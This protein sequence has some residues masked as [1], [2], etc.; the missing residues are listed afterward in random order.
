MEPVGIGVRHIDAGIVSDSARYLLAKL[1]DDAV[2]TQ[3]PWA[4]SVMVMIRNDL[5]IG[6]SSSGPMR[7]SHLRIRLASA[8]LQLRMLRI[9]SI[10]ATSEIA[11][12]AQK[13]AVAS[14]VP[15]VDPAILDDMVRDGQDPLVLDA[16]SA[17]EHALSHISGARLADPRSPIPATVSAIDAG[18]PIVLYSALGARS[19][20]LALRIEAALP[21]PGWADIY[22]LEGGIFRWHREGRLLVD[23]H[24]TA[25]RVHPHNRL[26]RRLLHGR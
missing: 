19:T 1:G 12:F 3:M 24:G 14:G 18:R 22:N 8:H 13:L 21:N 9:A 10:D 26:L 17:G 23:A 5:R 25:G 6:G 16:R 7:F 2:G 15:Q 11:A 20:R 4:G